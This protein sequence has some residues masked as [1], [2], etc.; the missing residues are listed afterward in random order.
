MFSR[1]NVPLAVRSS[2]LLEDSHRQPLA[3]LYATY[4]LPNNH[5]DLEVRLNHLETAVKL[6]Y[7]SAYVERPRRYFEAIG[8]DLAEARMAVIVQEIAGR[9][10]GRYFYPAHL[11]R[12]PVSQLL[13][14]LPDEAGG[15]RGDHRPGLGQTGGRR[16]R[17]GALLPALPAGAAAVPVARRSNER[18][19]AGVSSPW[20]SSVV[21]PTCC[22]A[23]MPRWP[24]C[25]SRR[26]KRT[27]RWRLPAALWMRTRTG[28]TTAWAGAAAACV[29]FA[30]ILKHHLF[31]LCAILN[32]LFEACRRD[33]GFRGRDRVCRGP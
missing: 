19:P 24:G 22:A 6:V 16:W 7:A 31:P 20:T 2:G 18:R 25:N 13:S 33:L 28:S 1:V 14:G 11:G 8:Q 29:T 3:G 30:R 12:G 21:M 26:P 27:G 5:P 32:E 15:W 10:Y 23:P 17:R 4:M 9:R